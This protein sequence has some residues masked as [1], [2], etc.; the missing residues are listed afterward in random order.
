L[1]SALTRAGFETPRRDA[2]GKV[3]VFQDPFGN[4]W[5]L[6]EPAGE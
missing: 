1:H 2:Y 5:D 6:I 4:R 3:A